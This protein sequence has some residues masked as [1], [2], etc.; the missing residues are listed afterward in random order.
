MTVIDDYLKKIEP[1]KKEELQRIRLLAKK[2]V[3]NAEEIISYNMPT[4][5]YQGKPF[6]GFDAHKSHIGIYPFSGYVT[7]VLKDKLAPYE[8]SSGAI[9]I[10]YNNPISENLLKEV[11][12]VRLQ[13]IDK[14]G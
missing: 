14:Q 6:L 10:P 8:F 1:S 7:E 5:T 9:R 2:I 3:P 13:Q 12:I 11:I 4:L